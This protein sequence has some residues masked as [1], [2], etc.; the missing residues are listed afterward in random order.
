[1]GLLDDIRTGSYRPSD[2]PSGPRPPA[3]PTQTLAGVARRAAAGEDFR[4]AVREFLDDFALA[5]Q[6]GRPRM[7]D[8]DPPPTGDE[9]HDAFLG[10]LAEHLAVRHGEPPPRWC[11]DPGRF[12]DRFWF[13]S[14]TP[15]FRAIALAQASVAFKRRGVL[16]PERSLMRV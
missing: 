11:L 10:A 3:R 8:E 7:L 1:M 5:S 9:R 6:G 13:V 2:A 15:G 14:A 16:I 12:L 4:V